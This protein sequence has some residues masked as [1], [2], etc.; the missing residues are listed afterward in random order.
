VGQQ[1]QT[2]SGSGTAQT[3]LL[4]GMGSSRHPSMPVSN[5]RE[6]SSS[7]LLAQRH[8]T[9]GLSLTDILPDIVN[10]VAADHMAAAHLATVVPGPSAGGPDDRVGEAK[11]TPAGYSQHEV[12][13][14]EEDVHGQQQP[15]RGQQHPDVRGE[16]LGAMRQGEL[17]ENLLAQLAASGEHDSALRHYV[18]HQ[19]QLH[20]RQQEIQQHQQSEAKRRKVSH[21]HSGEGD[22]GRVADNST[23]SAIFTGGLASLMTVSE[24]TAPSS[25]GGLRVPVTAERRLPLPGEPAAY[26]IISSGALPDSSQGA[27]PRH[28]QLTH[29]PAGNEPHEYLYSHSVPGDAA[30]TSVDEML[31]EIDCSSADDIDAESSQQADHFG[32]AMI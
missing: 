5:D 18:H 6:R 21:N 7:T 8:P 30:Q 14:T 17:D 10:T 3:S 29:R 23:S 4:S 24:D 19:E 1:S 16:R 20:H 28:R 32:I 31:R 25:V 15:I 27:P 12:S 22:G 9:Y 26:Q 13:G 11:R 2:H